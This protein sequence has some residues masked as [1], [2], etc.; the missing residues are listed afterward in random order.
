MDNRDPGRIGIVKVH[1]DATIDLADG[2][3]VRLFGVRI[4]PER[5]PASAYLSALRRHE[6][7]EASVTVYLEEPVPA[8][9]LRVWRGGAICGNALS[10]WDPTARP[11]RLWSQSPVAGNLAIRFET[12]LSEADLSDP[13]ADLSQV[14]RLRSSHDYGKRYRAG[15][16]R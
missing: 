1:E 9:E 3:T 7:K 10:T 14:G 8:V 5:K 16:A 2:R 4:P 12:A 15:K 13:Q 11:I 6:G